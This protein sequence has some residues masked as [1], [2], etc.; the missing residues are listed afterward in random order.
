MIRTEQWSRVGV[1]HP[2]REY[3]K[4]RRIPRPDE[5][6]PEDPHK[7]SPASDLMEEILGYALEW[8]RERQD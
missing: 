8:Q 5:D 4:A 3:W 6:T 1:N 7:F 2:R